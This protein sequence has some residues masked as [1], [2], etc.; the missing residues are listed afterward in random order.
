MS[1]PARLRARP[2]PARPAPRA[3]SA[4]RA[5][6][7][8]K[9]QTNEAYD[10]NSQ[11]ALADLNARNFTQAQEGAQADIGRRLSADQ[12]NAGNAPDGGAVQRQ[13]GTGGGA[14]QPAR[15]QWV[16]PKMRRPNSPPGNALDAAKFNTGNDSGQFLA[17]QFRSGDGGRA[18]QPGSAQNEASRFN[19]GN[20]ASRRPGQPARR[21]HDVAQQFNAEALRASQQ[22]DID[23]A[24]AALGLS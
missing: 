22:A 1:G 9:A 3:R 23:N 8:W 6:R 18:G 4:A 19:A 10:R 2:M 24:S 7:C 13:S 15:K 21:R 20:A 17:A 14:G 16:F 12:F 5:R 11:T